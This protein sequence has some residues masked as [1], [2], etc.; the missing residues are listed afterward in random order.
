MSIGTELRQAREA[1]SLSLDQVAQT[2]HIRMHYLEALEADNFELLP[3]TAQ[4]RGFLRVYA[5]YLRLNSSELVGAL[6]KDK[7]RNQASSGITYP[8]EVINTEPANSDAIF[9]E[10]GQK[11][12]SQRELMALSLEDVERHSHIRIHYLRAL[13]E[14]DISH[15]PS[16]VQ[17]RGMLSNYASFLGLATETI[18]LRF[19]DGLQ[20]RLY[21]RQTA[22]KGIAA[23]SQKKEDYTAPARPSQLKRLFSMDL[24]IGGFLIVFLLGFT[25]WGALRISKLHSGETPSPTAPPVSEILLST[26]NESLTGTPDITPEGLM[27]T[28]PE[29]ISATSIVT[30]TVALNQPTTPAVFEPTPPLASS[31]VQVYVVAHQR[32]WMRVTVDGEVA[33]EGRVIPGSAYSFAGNERIELLTGDAA[34]LQVYF[35]QQDLGTLGGFGEVVVRI[36]SIEGV[37]TATPAIPPTQTS[38]PTSSITPTPTPTRTIVPVTA[39]STPRP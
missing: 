35:N 39:T 22:K 5:D 8:L 6:D 25:V 21:D 4:V 12:Q 26:P 37:Q 10:I 7:Q 28:P 38:I 33:F 31:P 9:K 36:Y 2:T 14:G 15:L 13:E 29:T 11:L 24:F 19:A 17:G 20:A 30:E 23:G 1:Q 18:L 27:T 3:S 34:G 32:A 16:P